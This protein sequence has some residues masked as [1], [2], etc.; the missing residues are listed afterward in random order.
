MFNV[1]RSIIFC[2]HL[3]LQVFSYQFL[4]F[5]AM[6][7]SAVINVEFVFLTVFPVICQL[8]LRGFIIASMMT[9][10][11]KTFIFLTP[12]E[13]LVYLESLLIQFCG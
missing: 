9:E 4:A 3:F 7:L 8:F 11:S 2:V 13:V 12:L 1:V 10:A 5:S 6:I